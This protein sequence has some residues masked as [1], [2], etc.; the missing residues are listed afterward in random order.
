MAEIYRVSKKY[1][2]GFEYFSDGYQEI[3]YRGNKNVLWKANF[4]QI[5]L[6]NFPDLEL[7]K[8]EKYKYLEDGNIDLMFLL[9]KK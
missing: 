4:A 9:R 6:D 1:I 2:W 7:V 3:E 5:Y 8:T